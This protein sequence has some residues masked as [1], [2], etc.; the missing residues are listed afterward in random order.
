[1]V[2]PVLSLASEYAHILAPPG[3]WI[4]GVKKARILYSWVGR[5]SALHLYVRFGLYIE[6]CGYTLDGLYTENGCM[7]ITPDRYILVH[8][9][10]ISQK[11]NEFKMTALW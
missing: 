8:F 3:E 1:M 7:T 11:S 4:T 9:K 2:D 5:D 6:L 10:F